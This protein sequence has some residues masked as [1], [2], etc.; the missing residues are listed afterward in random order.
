MTAA[1]AKGP[2]HRSGAG[3]GGW[4]KP[5][6]S[7]T[8]VILSVA[9]PVLATLRASLPSGDLA[10]HVRAGQIML[11]THTFLHT[12]PFT[13]TVAGKAWLNQQWGSQLL[14]AWIF[15][16]GG[17]PAMVLLRASLSGLAFLLTYRATR[18]AGASKRLGAWLTLGA[19]LVT[20]QLPGSLALRPQLFAVTLFAILTW[21]LALRRRRPTLLLAV[22]AIAVL[23]ANIHGSFPMILLAVG[24][25]LLD[26]VVDR[27]PVARF[28]LAAAVSAVVLPLLNP[29]GPRVLSYIA[30]LSTNPQITQ[31]VDEWRPAT[32]RSPAGAALLLAIVLLGVLLSRS[33]AA[34]SARTL[35]AVGAFTLLVLWSVRNIVWWGIFV[36]PLVARDLDATTGAPDED[37]R[38][39]TGGLVLASVLALAI[40]W[41][42]W[43][44]SPDPSPTST[45]LLG[46]A[47]QGITN[48]LQRRL[49]PGD[50]LFNG[51]WGS[52]FEFSLPDNPV[53]VDSRIELIPRRIWGQFFDVSRGREGWRQVLDLWDVDVVVAEWRQQGLLIPKLERDAT[54]QKVYEDSDGLVFVRA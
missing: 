31:G 41:L 13:Y 7:D 51:S 46:Q 6:A 52:W 38:S 37:A 20:A 2:S 4:W 3:S 10:Y 1:N 8:W 15:G 49:K 36:A 28:T 23:W 33:A 26:D 53:F 22:P 21:I 17:W 54:W 25:T 43:V 30:Q 11:D 45:A 48:E 40:L 27:H 44:R 24:V 18:A 50:R 47:P 39:V 34:P 12:D 42:P 19:F 32:V 16:R 35:L 14:L 9:L 29:Y 5:T